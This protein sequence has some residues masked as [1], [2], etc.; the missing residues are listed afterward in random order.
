LDEKLICGD[1]C[2]EPLEQQP[3]NILA[4]HPHQG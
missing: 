1:H 4:F 3:E 2:S